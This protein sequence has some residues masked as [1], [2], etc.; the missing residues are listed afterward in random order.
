MSG[1]EPR[2][3]ALAAVR[4]MHARQIAEHGGEAGIRDPSGLESALARPRQKWSYSD[5]P[6]DLCTLAAAYAFGIA[7]NHPFIDGNK[8]T[9]VV[10][11]EAFLWLHGVEVTPTEEEKYPVYLA[12]AAG[13]LSEEE[14][15]TWLR[16]HTGPSS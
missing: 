16:K 4:L 13:D 6:P 10:V 3:I 15:A 11:C 7:K 2:W 12:L 5:P 9:S 8:R 14:F 1:P